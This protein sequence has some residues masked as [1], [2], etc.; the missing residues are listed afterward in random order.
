M[1]RINLLPREI[2]ETSQGKKSSFLVFGGAF[3]FVAL[4]AGL[5]LSRR[6]RL[7]SLEREVSDVEAQIEELKPIVAEVERI[8]SEIEELDRRYEVL[9]SLVRTRFIYPVFMEK[10]TE[11]TPRDTWIRRMDTDTEDSRLL[12]DFSVMARDNYAVA[13]FISAI[14]EHPDFSEVNFTGI[15]TETVDVNETPVELRSFSVSCVYEH[16]AE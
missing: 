14:E 8:R 7:S 4:I 6:V 9:G 10:L 2:K 13:D 3:L 1:I 12:V 5:Y 15:S 16:S 11:I